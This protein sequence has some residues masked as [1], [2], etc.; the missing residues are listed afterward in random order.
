MVKM[1]IMFR[2]PSTPD[3][4]ER[5]NQSLALL[6]KLPGIRRKQVN[7]VIGA[8]NGAAPFGRIMELYFDNRKTLEDALLTPEGQA[9]GLDLMTWARFDSEILYTEVYEE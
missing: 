6:E 5:Y 4:E 7:H 9:A 3:F 1:I 2:Q 8:P